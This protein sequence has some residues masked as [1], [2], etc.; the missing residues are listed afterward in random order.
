MHMIFCCMH[1]VSENVTSPLSSSISGGSN[2][3]GFSSSGG[4]VF[5]GGASGGG[6][7]SSW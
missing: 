5:F 6:G 2:G 3:V 4:G 1:I 7:G